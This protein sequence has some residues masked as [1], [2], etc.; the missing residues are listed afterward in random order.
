MDAVVLGNVGAD[1]VLALPT[2]HHEGHFS[3]LLHLGYLAL[4]EERNAPGT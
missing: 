3:R 4:V 2:N 1:S